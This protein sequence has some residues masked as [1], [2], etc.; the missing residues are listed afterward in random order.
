[1]PIVDAF[2]RELDQ[3]AKTTQRVLERIPEEKLTW[4][5]HPRSKSIGELAMHLATIPGMF[6]SA[7]VADSFEFS[8]HTTPLAKN[9]KDILDEFS[10]NIAAAKESL[11]KLDDARM[12]ASWSA[13]MK[14]KTLMT[15]PRI[16]LVRSL[17]LNHFY[18]H[19]GQLS[20]Y[21]RLLDIPVPSIYGPS[22]D[23][24]PFA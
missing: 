20:V 6:A 12:M 14:G 18:H 1:M 7:A 17:L 24:N 8:G 21:L 10:K 9:R 23:E 5:P 2:L 19:R 13:N 15:M 4:K 3:E 11:K 22:A 16:A